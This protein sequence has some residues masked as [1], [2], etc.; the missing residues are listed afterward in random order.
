MVVCKGLEDE[1]A[2]P[3]AGTSCVLGYGGRPGG[4]EVNKSDSA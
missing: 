4:D 2:D 1:G 3:E